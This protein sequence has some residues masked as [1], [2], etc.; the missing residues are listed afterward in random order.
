MANRIAGTPTPATI[1]GTS[2]AKAAPNRRPTP[3]RRLAAEPEPLTASDFA[4]R[5]E[6]IGV[7]WW[8]LIQ[9]IFEM[10]GTAQWNAEPVPQ[11]VLD[12][13]SDQGRHRDTYEEHRVKAEGLRELLRAAD[14][15]P[16]KYIYEVWGDRN[17]RLSLRH[18]SIGDAMPEL[19]RFKDSGKWP[20]AAIIKMHRMNT[21]A[22]ASDP[23]LLD[24]LVG[25]VWY[26]GVSLPLGEHDE[27]VFQIQD[28]TGRTVSLP[29]SKLR[30]HPVI[31]RITNLRNKASLLAWLQEDMK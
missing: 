31:E 17:T 6:E 22:M 18:E 5:I 28:A 11:W 21:G 25:Q 29:A 15:L 12:T 4:V 7:H 2:P 8:S 13:L 30:G 19:Q 24:T 23:A 20:N 27:H 1:A 26:A 10:K 16:A 3:P 14:G 9:G